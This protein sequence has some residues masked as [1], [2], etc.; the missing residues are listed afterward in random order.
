VLSV[1][2]FAWLGVL[3]R[4]EHVARSSGDRIFYAPGLRAEQLDH[5]LE[6]LKQARLLDPDPRVDQLRANLLLLRGR[7]REAGE[8][9]ARLVRDEPAYL[10]A[11]TILYR[12]TRGSDPQRAAA[13]A[14][15][16]RRLNPLATAPATARAAPPPA[17][18]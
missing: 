3:L 12:A 11:W 10:E 13:A 4:N 7:R 8:L 18:R 9:A 2:I 6:R 15:E 5:E 14:T 1:A 16:I 17:Q